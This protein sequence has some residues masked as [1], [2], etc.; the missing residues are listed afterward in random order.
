MKTIRGESVTVVT[1][2]VVDGRVVAA[3]T[4][5]EVLDVCTRDDDTKFVVIDGAIHNI[6]RG[7]V[8]LTK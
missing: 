2:T 1:Q 5:T 7:L 4:S 6:I 3:T 8:L